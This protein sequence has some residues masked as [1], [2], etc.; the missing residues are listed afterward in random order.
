MA[1]KKQE[2]TQ[3]VTTTTQPK[4]SLDPDEW[5]KNIPTGQGVYSTGDTGVSPEY[6]P[7]P[8]KEYPQTAKRGEIA[9][10]VN[11]DGS[12]SP[13]YELNTRPGEILASLEEPA[14]IKTINLLYSRGWYGG[15]EKGGGISENDKKAVE[16]LLYYSNL[17]GVD[18]K[19]VLATVAKAPISQ[20]SGV[21]KQQVASKAD[22]IEIA[23]RSALSTIGRKLT[24]TEA[25]QF[26]A[27]YQ[28]VQRT[29]FSGAE[30]A[31]SADVFFQNRIQ[32]K[33][34]TESDG[35]KYLSAIS[36]VSKL[37]ENI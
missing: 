27:S 5:K 1:A 17:I 20:P 14:R 8:R 15:R 22:L 37:L 6:V 9:G 16:N 26:A 4:G 31:P 32:Q 34:G 28:G 7:A 12:V 30:T 11:P 10:I 35:Y 3:P 33:Y 13:Y 21:G 25:Q 36:N 18:Y 19:T 29:S 2:G 23:N 24:E